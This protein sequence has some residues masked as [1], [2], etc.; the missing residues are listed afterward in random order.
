[1][2]TVEYFQKHKDLLN[3]I[4]NIGTPVF[5]TD[6]AV[7]QQKVQNIKNAFGSNCLLYYAIKANFNPHIVE[8]LKKEGIDEIETVSPYEI[9]K[10]KK[11]RIW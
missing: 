4:I 1:M 5:V 3:R 10:K 7:L 11:S 9:K 8:T 2:Q 6:K